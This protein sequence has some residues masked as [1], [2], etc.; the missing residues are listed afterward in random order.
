[1]LF[2]ML[3]RNEEL[4]LSRKA[5]AE[6][7]LENGIADLLGTETTGEMPGL[8]TGMIL[9]GETDP[10]YVANLGAALIKISPTIE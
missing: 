3:R 10:F 7:R 6:S 9:G 5:Y 1:M 2:S 8:L 4:L